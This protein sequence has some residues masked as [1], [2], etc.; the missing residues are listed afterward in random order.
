MEQGNPNKVTAIVEEIVKNN[1]VFK[2]K[3]SIEQ[4]KEKYSIEK[5]IN[6]ALSEL[7]EVGKELVLQD[8]SIDPDE[9][10]K[11]FID[12][13]G[14]I[15]IYGITKFTAIIV[16]N[17]IEEA[18]RDGLDIRR[19][20]PNVF[21]K[22]NENKI[23]ESVISLAVLDNLV[24]NYEDLSNSDRKKITENWEN[25]TNAQRSEVSRKKAGM[26]EK[27]L[28]EAKT[29]EERQ[30]IT[31]FIETEINNAD[32][33]SQIENA[34][35]ET[36]QNLA[37]QYTKENGDEF[38]EFRKKYSKLPLR[39]IIGKF[40]ANRDKKLEE[41]IDITIDGTVERGLTKNAT[42]YKEQTLREKVVL[43]P[44][45]LEKIGGME[46]WHNLSLE[47]Q[48]RVAVGYFSNVHQ[49][50]IVTPKE[51]INQMATKLQEQNIT[52][53][54]IGK[55][56]TI[57]METLKSLGLDDIENYRHLVKDEELGKVQDEIRSFLIED[58]ISPEIAEVL[59]KID[60]NGQLYEI[61]GDEN[62]RQEFFEQLKRIGKFKEIPPK[63]S[64]EK[65]NQEE[66][67]EQS[68]PED[69]S[70]ELQAIPVALQ[71]INCK[72]EDI[73]KGMELYKQIIEGLSS[74]EIEG[75]QGNITEIL[76]KEVE[77][78]GL[79][80]VAGDI[81]KMM[82]QITFNGQLSEIL[83]NSKDVFL[84]SLNG[85]L[86]DP[87]VYAINPEQSSNN[88][89]T[90]SSVPTEKI[91]EDSLKAGFAALAVD[92]QI[93]NPTIIRTEELV[94]NNEN[95]VEVS[96]NTG[97]EEKKTIKGNSVINKL[98]TVLGVLKNTGATTSDLEE[99][100]SDLEL[101]SQQIENDKTQATTKVQ[102]VEE[103]DNEEIEQ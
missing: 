53:E 88:N 3:S 46:Y 54:E 44:Q 5:S 56:L 86:L 48:T 37:D 8:L 77:E 45:I 19:D 39:D 10:F 28:Q 34:T 91:D 93:T 35:D 20:A 22:K 52:E 21:V 101:V 69:I 73:A 95:Q 68:L 26:L 64:E 87:R 23:L 16:K 30:I 100:M 94:T 97:H 12:G 72:P 85:P 18:E 78:L 31:D 1:N 62:S 9:K 90:N 82:S 75:T 24:K 51:I 32:I 66:K 60:Y 96:D 92:L 50:T 14:N 13:A 49:Q 41:T 2:L 80:G 70:A 40:K 25:L 79:D 11:G 99:E 6:I 74:E 58:G 67:I 59:S 63:Q 47:E 98:Q 83:K 71:R 27:R 15:D 81:L 103:K 61:L 17:K 76:Q 36:L 38:E 43:N 29:A 7:N 84:T 4:D 57:E 102:I 55:I 42:K 89:A 65:S 33:Y